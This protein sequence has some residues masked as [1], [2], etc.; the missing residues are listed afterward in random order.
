MEEFKS[1]KIVYCFSSRVA[2]YLTR[3]VQWLLE[4]KANSKK[5]QFD[6]FLFE[7]TEELRRLMAEYSKAK[8]EKH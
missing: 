2:G 6:V 3:H 7:D 4:T 5:P 8:K 1:L